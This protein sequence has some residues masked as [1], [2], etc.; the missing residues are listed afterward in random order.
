MVATAALVFS[1]AWL[2]EAQEACDLGIE[3]VE[4]CR[5]A[6]G[7]DYWLVLVTEAALTFG[8]VGLA[9]VDGTAGERAVLTSNDIVD[10]AQKAFG[11]DHWVTLIAAAAR[12][13]ALAAAGR[14]DAAKALGDDTLLRC[15]RTL[16]GQHPIAQNLRQVL[17]PA[18]PQAGVPAGSHR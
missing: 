1:H 6:F 3:S 15:N 14:Q 8:L 5:Q 11:A 12:T 2:G 7:L 13:F 17:E 16:G 4:R 10:R 9:R 18:L